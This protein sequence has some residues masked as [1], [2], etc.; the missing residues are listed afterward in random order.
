MERPGPAEV[1][2]AETSGDRRRRGP[3]QTGRARA[4]L[5]L[6]VAGAV[7]VLLGVLAAL[8]RV[9]GTGAPAAEEAST[10]A[11]SADAG[12]RVALE[13]LLAARSAAV[14]AGD[15]G[16]VLAG[17]DPA[18]SAFAARQVDLVEGLTRLPLAEWSY[19]VVAVGPGPAGRPGS[20]EADTLLSYRLE[21]VDEV[22]QVR[23]RSFA[24]EEQ[25]AGLVLVG[26][27]E[28]P[29]RPDPWDLGLVDVVAGER[30]F[31]VGTAPR[32]VLAE[33]AV[34]GDAAARQVDAA[35]GTGWPRRTV[36]H[37]PA[38]LDQLARLLG[39]AGGASPDVTGL[40]Q[41][42]ALTTGADRASGEP[43]A[44]GAVDRVVVNPAALDQLGELGRAVVLT[45]ETTHVAVRAG[46]ADD[47]PPW[48][49]EGFAELVA[50][51]GATAGADDDVLPPE[52]VA[53]GTL[54]AVRAGDGPTALPGPAAFDP[55]GGDVAPAY[56]QSFLAARTVEQRHGRQ[57][58]L[59]L[60]RAS[61]G[62]AATQQEAAVAPLP[63]ERAVPEVLGVTLVELEQQ[64]LADLGSLAAGGS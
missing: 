25:D 8:G 9:P 1:A 38:D 14:L 16:G 48:L 61:A 21:G 59:D 6:A 23:H 27:G 17:V 28:T 60:V 4:A 58:L 62:R 37:V 56:G 52:V 40:D 34:L 64:W 50:Y 30:T 10:A 44:E 3:A 2:G 54:A 12:R 53:A 33:Q 11:T 45:H 39:R 7:L 63:A 15:V 35:W 13:E 36:L 32:A 42:A 18:A 47:P 19:D 49:S 20:W 31:V 46:A 29:G 43:G 5:V 55:T 51:G 57:A 26:D 24:V 41:L 22:P